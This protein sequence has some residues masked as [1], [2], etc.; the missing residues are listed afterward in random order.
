VKGLSFFNRIHIR[1]IKTLWE[2]FTMKKKIIATF[3]VTA[4]LLTALPMTAFAG[5]HHGGGHNRN[6]GNTTT[7]YA[8]CATESCTLT[9]LHRHN[10]RTFAAHYHGDGHDYHDYCV[11]ENCVVSGYHEHDGTFHFGH[12]AN[13][14]HKNHNS[15]HRGG[16]H[17]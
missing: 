11:V 7:R 12:H 9:G 6:T 8:V 5:G 15:Q 1:I 2:D 13:D 10:G 17:H 3:I 4:L 16:R 14:G